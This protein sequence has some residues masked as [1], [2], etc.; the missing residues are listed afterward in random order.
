[1]IEKVACISITGSNRFQTFAA[2]QIICITWASITVTFDA[3]EIPD[4]RLKR[5]V[6]VNHT[7]IQCLATV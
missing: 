6:T 4:R 5:K 7:Y 1:M 2:N 3:K